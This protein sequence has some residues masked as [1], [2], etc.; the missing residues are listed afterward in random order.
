[1]NAWKQKGEQASKQTNRA[2]DHASMREGRANLLQGVVPRVAL[3][4]K[5]S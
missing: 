5:L 4:C 3:S 2:V 1:M